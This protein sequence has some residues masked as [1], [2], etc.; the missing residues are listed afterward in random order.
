[1][2]SDNQHNYTGQCLCGQIQYAVDKID[3]RMAHCHCSMC[4]KFHGAAFATYGEARASRFHWIAGEEFLKSFVASN[5]TVRKFCKHC[6]A[7]L[8][9][10]SANS[11]NDTVEFALGTLDTPIA[12]KP[13]AHIYT[14]YKANWFTIDDDL[15]CCKEGRE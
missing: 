7:S 15:P 12:E 9:F 1:M 5:G 6:G 14:N 2:N 3:A 8:I 10:Q 13:D 11:S 4:R